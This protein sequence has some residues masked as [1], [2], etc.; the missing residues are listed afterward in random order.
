MEEDYD[1]HMTRAFTAIIED[2]QE[3][4]LFEDVH[5]ERIPKFQ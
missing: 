4:V 1:K 2:N 3:N 5:F